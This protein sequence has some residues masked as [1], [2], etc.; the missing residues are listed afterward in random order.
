MCKRLKSIPMEERQICDL[1]FPSELTQQDYQNIEDVGFRQDT[2]SQVF[3]LARILRDQ[4]P[5]SVR[6]AFLQ[7]VADG[8]YPSDGKKNCRQACGIIRKL[9][10]A[11]IIPA[12]WVMDGR[13]VVP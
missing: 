11:G 2:I 8:I 1:G 3:V 12:S 4:K 10:R 6:N 9:R 5:I 13:E 7:A